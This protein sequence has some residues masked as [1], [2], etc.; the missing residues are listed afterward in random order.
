MWYRLQ[1]THLNGRRYEE[2]ADLFASRRLS[3]CERSSGF[4]EWTIRASLRSRQGSPIPRLETILKLARALQVDL[5]DLID[6]AEL[7]L[8]K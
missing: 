2:A 4:Q 8:P 5:N 6:P 3:A 7:G 1:L